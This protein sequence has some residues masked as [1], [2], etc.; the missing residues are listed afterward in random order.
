VKHTHLTCPL[1]I[2]TDG[3]K[4]GKTEQG[5]VWLDPNKT[6]P[7]HFYQFW[8]NVSDEEAARYIKIFTLLNREE[9]EGLI[10]ENN[11]NPQER[12]L[13]KKLAEEITVMVHSHEEY[14]AAVDASQILFG[15]GTTETLRKMSESTFL[16]VFEGVPSY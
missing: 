3:T 7:Y 11:K 14:K 1:I 12:I 16:S 13:Q 6:S 4:F 10:S 8:L 5:N 9:I 15:K 2:K